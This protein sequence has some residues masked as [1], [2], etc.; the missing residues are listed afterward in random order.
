MV[1]DDESIYGTRY[2][3]KNYADLYPDRIKTDIR[4]TKMPVSHAIRQWNSP[5]IAVFIEVS[6]VCI[7]LMANCMMF[8]LCS[9]FCSPLPA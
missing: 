7:A 5:D 6:S 9:L 2:V 8:A 3:V 1:V 4:K